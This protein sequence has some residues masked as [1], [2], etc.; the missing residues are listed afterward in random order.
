MKQTLEFS[1]IL[2]ISS[3]Q[4]KHALRIENRHQETN[5]DD[6]KDT[7]TTPIY[8]K[9]NKAGGKHQKKNEKERTGS[10]WLTM[11]PRVEMAF[12]TSSTFPAENSNTGETEA[13]LGNWSFSRVWFLVCT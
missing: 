10:H 8:P 11:D 6:T 3:S 13:C 2:L 7:E 5:V 12:F 1:F 4:K 9:G